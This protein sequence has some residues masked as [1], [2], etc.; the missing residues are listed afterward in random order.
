MRAAQVLVN[1]RT[2]RHGYACGSIEPPLVQRVLIEIVGSVRIG[3][4]E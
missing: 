3:D 2:G 4:S 1:L